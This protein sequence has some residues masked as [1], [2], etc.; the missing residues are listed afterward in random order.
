MPL[1][2][3]GRRK[4]R[5]VHPVAGKGLSCEAL[6][7]CGAQSTTLPGETGPRPSETGPAQTSEVLSS[8]EEGIGEKTVGAR[9]HQ[10]SSWISGHGEPCFHLL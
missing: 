6:C 7:V 2:G 3:R 8:R 1:Q 4:P 9:E 10:G 5:H